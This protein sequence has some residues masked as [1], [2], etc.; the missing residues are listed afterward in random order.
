MSKD[1]EQSESTENDFLKQLRSYDDVVD[2]EYDSFAPENCLYTPSPYF[3]W[4]F[5]N[6]SHGIP[7][8]ASV[9]FLSEQK[10]GKSLCCYATILEMQRRDPKA[11]SIFF[12][13]ELRG[14]LQHNIFPEIN[15]KRSI[16]YDTKDPVE[17]FDRIEN[18]VKPMVQDGMKLG[19]IVIDS[20]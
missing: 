19:L 2:Y 3:N 16:I 1:N 7:K 5:A 10:A 15:K 13:T 12:N 8:N 4:I 20:L 6:K 18:D 11:I 14:Q 9:L 17:I